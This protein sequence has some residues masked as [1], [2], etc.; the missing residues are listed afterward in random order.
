MT[1]TRT[2]PEKHRE[3]V[4]AANRARH[5]ATKTLIERHR[6]EFDLLYEIEAAKEGVEPKPRTDVGEIDSLRQQVA[7]L[8][9]QVQSAVTPTAGR[10]RA[11]V[12]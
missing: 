8:A 5:R 7:R 12:G 9:A 10:K 4:R 3:Q 1:A 6:S 2:D 11:K